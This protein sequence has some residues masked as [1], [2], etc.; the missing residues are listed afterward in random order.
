MGIYANVLMEYVQH[1][2]TDETIDDAF[3]RAKRHLHREGLKTHDKLI[4]ETLERRLTYK[5][6]VYAW[7][8]GMNSAL[9]WWDVAK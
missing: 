4:R 5:D 7:P 3:A 1:R 2:W 9:V 8:D 6:G